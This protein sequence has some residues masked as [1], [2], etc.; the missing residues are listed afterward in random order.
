MGGVS[1]V[2]HED[3]LHGKK[4][5]VSLDCLEH[6]VQYSICLWGVGELHTED[7]GQTSRR[8]HCSH[9]H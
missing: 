2:A 4:I 6:G 1:K 9:S 7:A 3:E 8:T 5:G